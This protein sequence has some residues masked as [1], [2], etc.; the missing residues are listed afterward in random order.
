MV[1]LIFLYIIRLPWRQ[2]KQR[3]NS[4]VIG[5]KIFLVSA[6]DVGGQSFRYNVAEVRNFVKQS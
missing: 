5:L 2:S 6:S 3:Y 4:L 1:I